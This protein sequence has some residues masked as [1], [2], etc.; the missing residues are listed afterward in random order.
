MKSLANEPAPNQ[1]G[2]TMDQQHAPSPDAIRIG[3]IEIRYLIDGSGAGHAGLF[4]MTLPPQ[5]GTPPRGSLRPPRPPAAA[6]TR[7]TDPRRRQRCRAAP[8]P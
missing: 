3:R 1:Q 2:D 6:T 7:D 4:E 5:S 8:A